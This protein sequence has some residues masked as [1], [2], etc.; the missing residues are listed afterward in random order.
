MDKIV[1][2][3]TKKNSNRSEPVPC[4]HCGEMIEPM[5]RGSFWLPGE[6]GCA[7][8]AKERKERKRRRDEDREREEEQRKKWAVEAAK[9]QAGLD[10]RL[11]EMT[12]ERFDATLQP[13]AYQTALEFDGERSL[14]FHSQG[15][16]TGKTHLAVAILHS[17]V[18]KGQTGYFLHVPSLLRRIRD[19]FHPSAQETEDQIMQR[20]ERAD[21]VIL[22]DL[23][24]EKAS[25]WQEMT[26]YTLVN[27]RY[28]HRLPLIIT[29]NLKPQQLER[30]IGPASVSRLLGMADFVEMEGS[31]YRLKEKRRGRDV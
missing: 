26:L 3:A 20:I 16:G 6:C 17:W 2:F 5:Q 22:D 12:F 24:K 19:T 23:G 1:N 25:E 29:M 4:R 9:N 15:Y 31:D 13:K 30:Q 18:E 28:V 21:L 8:A 14:V 11:M 10:G 27:Y 7:E